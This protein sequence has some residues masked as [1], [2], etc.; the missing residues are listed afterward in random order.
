MYCYR[1]LTESAA[2]RDAGEGSS[3][4]ASKLSTT[5][6]LNVIN[7]VKMTMHNRLKMLGQLKDFFNKSSYDKN[8]QLMLNKEWIDFFQ[9]LTYAQIESIRKYSLIDDS[10]GKPENGEKSI[11]EVDEKDK[12]VQKSVV[13]T[14]Q[15]QEKVLPQQQVKLVSESK[16]YFSIPK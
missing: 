6:P 12:A 16:I 11:V 10:K 4:L 5:E 3:T 7:K 14:M 13:P 8:L 15:N 9:K 2:G 1:S